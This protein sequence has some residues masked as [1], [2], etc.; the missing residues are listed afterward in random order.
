MVFA[1][2]PE[3]QRYQDKLKEYEYASKKVTTEYIDPDKKPTVAQAEPD[4]AVR[5]DRLQ[6]Q[7]PHR[8]R[9]VRQ[10][11]G[12]HHRHHQGRQ[13]PAEEGLL[14]A[15]SRR[16]GHDLGGTRRLQ[17]RSPA[18]SAARTTRSTS[19]SSRSR[20]RCPTMRR[21][22]IVAGPRTDF[23]PPEI[24]ALKKYLGQVGQA[25]ARARPAGQARQP[26]AHAT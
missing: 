9:D 26:A 21:V 17:R 15:G 12:H 20:A 11:A 19:W 22:V 8:A 7:G 23:F 5:H 24:E 10:R 4:S 6:L 18:R 2:E 13:R 25:A 14:H 3:F 1:Q 16:E